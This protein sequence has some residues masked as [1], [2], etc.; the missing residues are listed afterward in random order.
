[1]IATPIVA[2]LGVVL[3]TRMEPPDVRVSPLSI[4][5]PS[6][7]P[8]RREVK[9]SSTKPET[10]PSMYARKRGRV[11]EVRLQGSPEQIGYAHSRLLHA[12]MVATERAV[13]AQFAE[14]VPLAPLRMLITDLGRFRF[15]HIDRFIPNSYRRELAAQ[16]LGFRPDPFASHMDTFQRFVFLQSLYDIALSFEHSPLVGCSSFTLSGAQTQEGH[17]LLGRNFDLE[18]PEVLDREKV[19]FLMFERDD[20][21][22][23]AIPYA[24]IS[25]PGFVGAATGMNA[26]G[27]AVVLHGARGGEAGHEGE[28]VAHT[29]RELLATARSTTEAMKRLKTK[30]AIVSHMVLLADAS[31]K[32]VVA[33]RVPGQE[34]HFREAPLTR[35][36][37]HLEGPQKLSPEN[38]R[39]ERE[40]SSLARRQRL[41][42][43]IENLSSPATV[44]DVVSIL[45]DKRAA[46]GDKLPLG[47]RD[48]IDGLLATHSVAMNLSTRELWVSEGPSIAGRFVR[49][50]LSKLLNPRYRPS[51]PPRV[52]TIEADPI[53]RDG[54]YDA[55]KQAGGQ[56]H[57][58]RPLPGSAP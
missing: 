37:N 10:A 5:S 43:R 35:L 42:E 48:S 16:A 44:K 47:H 1:M 24:S 57:D 27:L 52:E 32:V 26:A 7:D 15:R 2:H 46:G 45:R 58:A 20:R 21:G 11:G 25:W 54:R 33:E 41:D 19:V 3:L 17:V 9:L 13:H 36:T 22:Q 4:A 56:H 8:G 14:H 23:A 30:R 50:D 12:S 18:G 28:P 39:V 6:D 49:F 53:L 40:T 38:L 34:T 29:L 55:W 51:G 31:G